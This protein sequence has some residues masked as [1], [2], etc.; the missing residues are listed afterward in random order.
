MFFRFHLEYV[1]EKIKSIKFI[2]TSK[3]VR[4]IDK[5]SIKSNKRVDNE[6]NLRSS[7]RFLKQKAEANEDMGLIDFKQ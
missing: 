6:I 5:I 7:K 3:D 1:N 4:M 2:A